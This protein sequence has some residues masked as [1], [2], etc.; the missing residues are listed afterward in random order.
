MNASALFDLSG[1]VAIVTGAGMGIGRRLALGLAEHGARVV[2]ADI[3]GTRAP[4]VV[5][6]LEQARREALAVEC[7]VCIPTEVDRLVTATVER[8]GTVDV[9]VNN[10][11][12]TRG[13]GREP[14]VDL[15][16]EDWQATLELTLTSAFLCAQ[17]VGRVMIARRTGKVINMAS[18]YGLVGH[19][20]SLYDQ[21]PGGHPPEGLAYVAAKGGIV[22]MTRALAVYWAPFNITVNA[23]APG[24]VK[25]ER[26]SEAVSG[27]TW[28][29]LADRTPLGRP[30]TPEEIVGAA[31]FLASPAGDFVTGQTLVVDG[32]WTA[33]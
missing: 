6:E 7:D 13:R 2:V 22:S 33:W 1:R 25:T 31:V 3:D 27:E 10:V 8:F 20:A 23:I 12:G 29:R 4:R 24:M 16:L 28:Q 15:S 19:D 26:L 11:G 17:R 30:A 18:V 14:T 32:G 21:Q 9:L 5:D